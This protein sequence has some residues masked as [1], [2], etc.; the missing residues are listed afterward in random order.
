MLLLKQVSS[1][2]FRERAAKVAALVAQVATATLAL[3]V[4]ALS[5]VAAAI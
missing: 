2:P 1:V 5:A 4:V 3:R